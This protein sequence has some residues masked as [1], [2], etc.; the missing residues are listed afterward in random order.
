[1]RAFVIGNGPSLLDT[2]MDRLRDEF[3]I[4][5]NRFDL[6]NLDWDPDWW[7]LADVVHEDEWWDWDALFARKSMFVMRDQDKQYLD[8][9]PANVTFV[10]RCD[11]M[12]D[13]KPEEWHLDTMPC[14]YGGGISMA[15]QLAVTLGRNPVYLVGCDLYKYRGPDDVDIN[16][17]HPDYCEYKTWRGKEWNPPEVWEKLN[18]RLIHAHEIARYSAALMG[19]DI[20]NATAGG[21]L[22]VYERADINEL[23]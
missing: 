14:E 1:M 3:T 4:A 18:K 16:H 21:A 11:H 5:L 12:G 22:E 20:F 7:M 19:V 13:N 15:L 10:E 23:V 9:V 17:F 2:P 6:L 8:G